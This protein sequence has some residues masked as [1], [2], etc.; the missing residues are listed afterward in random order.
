[1]G[2]EQTLALPEERPSAV[3]HQRVSGQHGIRR[4]GNRRKERKQRTNPDIAMLAP[5][6][7]KRLDELLIGLLL[8][9]FVDGT[10][11][12]RAWHCHR[13]PERSFRVRGRQFH[14]CARCTG[15][16]VGGVMSPL[17][18]T[19]GPGLLLWVGSTSLLVFMFDSAAQLV[20]WRNST[21]RLR[22]V[23][24]VLTGTFVPAAV[25][26]AAWRIVSLWLR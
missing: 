18:V 14:I 15:L 9:I 26:S 16:V 5:I 3:Q 23:T 17:A 11:M 10:W 21:N 19:L 20:G 13:L 6:A 4:S 2:D 7:R 25:I 24:G 12:H 8:R 1:M 22:F